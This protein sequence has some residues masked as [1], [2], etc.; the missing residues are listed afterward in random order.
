[1]NPAWPPIPEGDPLDR[2][3][4]DQR[5][6][7]RAYQI[8]ETISQTRAIRVAS[9]LFPDE[10]ADGGDC[11]AEVGREGQPCQVC[12][13]RNAQWSNRVRQVRF[14]MMEAFK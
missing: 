4:E 10:I 1:M 5:G 12:A 9:A 8:G 13:E 3:P 6:N 11:R 14:A 7:P 2:R